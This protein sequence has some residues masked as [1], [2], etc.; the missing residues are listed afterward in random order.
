MQK[1][2]TYCHYVGKSKEQKACN[3]F[4]IYFSLFFCVITIFI[5]YFYP[6]VLFLTFFFILLLL[7]GIDRC[8]GDSSLC[9]KCEKYYLID[10]NYDEAQSIIKELNNDVSKTSPINSGIIY[11]LNRY[12]YEVPKLCTECFFIGPGKDS[13]HIRGI[14]KG[15]AWMVMGIISV[16][17]GYISPWSMVGAFL[18]ISTGGVFIV[19]TITPDKKCINC[20][21][22][23][24]VRLNSN[25]AKAIIEQQTLTPPITT[26][27]L[28]PEINSYVSST[29]WGLTMTVV[30]VLCYDLF[31]YFSSLN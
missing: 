15:I 5:S 29:I 11:K 25:S 10:I 1:L 14:I 9:P 19:A 26:K 28:L 7:T 23:A 27:P 8:F 13:K 6:F 3:K 2:C 16:L 12:S 22:K 21:K 30:A 18:L 20:G 4:V 24:R 31:R 17:L